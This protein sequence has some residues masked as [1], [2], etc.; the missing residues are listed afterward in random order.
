MKDFLNDLYLKSEDG[1]KTV[2]EGDV[3]KIVIVLLVFDCNKG[4]HDRM[5]N[6]SSSSKESYIT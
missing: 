2:T 1:H 3:T 5:K 4:E 6:P